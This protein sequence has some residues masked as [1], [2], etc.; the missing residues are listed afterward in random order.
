MASPPA[1]PP[2]RPLRRLRL[3]DVALDEALWARG[4]DARRREWQG[5][6]RDL[7]ETASLEIDD[8]EVP[9]HLVSSLTIET[10]GLRWSLG[11][12]RED[13]SLHLALPRYRLAPMVDE[14]AQVCAELSRPGH[15]PPRLEALDIAKRLVHDEGGALL[16]EIATPLVIDHGT[17]RRLFTLLVTVLVDTTALPIPPH[18]KGRVVG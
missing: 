14:Y 5:A 4:S 15:A 3:V 10:N 16:Q 1:S 17:G 12:R 7:I 9:E 13:P 11:G 18:Q 2:A 6:I 8:D